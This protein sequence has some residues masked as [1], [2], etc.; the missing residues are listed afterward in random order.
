MCYLNKPI[1]TIRFP[2]NKIPVCQPLNESMMYLDHY[3]FCESKYNH[4]KE[5]GGMPIPGSSPHIIARKTV[6]QKLLD[7]EKLLP[8]GYH[9]K[10]FDAYRP[11]SVQQVLW[12]YFR[13]KKI[14]ENPD[15]TD[16]EIDKLTAF[17]VSF[18]SYN[19]L[20]PSLHNTGGAVDLTIVDE[21]NKELDMGCDFDVFSD[22]SWTNHYE[23]DCYDGERNILVRDNRR[24]LYNVMIAVG[25]TNLPSEWWHYDFGDDKWAQI[26][27]TAPLYAG[28]LDAK[29]K[30]SE[31]YKDSNK[32]RKIDAEQ[33]ELIALI[34]DTRD[35]CKDLSIE[36]KNYIRH[37]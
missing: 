33:Q 36:L 12:D 35:K 27:G 17:C 25:F 11:I 26:T 29:I 9:F 6:V 15:K 30:D 3:F 28:I 18:P 16:N 24:M 23:P 31:P 19:V 7:A 14:K 22:K 37:K 20:E 21:N 8:K 1:P 5:N 34:I 4:W 10:I 32:I 13:E 2:E